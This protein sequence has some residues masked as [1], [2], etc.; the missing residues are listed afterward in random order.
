MNKQKY[1]TKKD[2]NP[3]ELNLNE[4]DVNLTLEHGH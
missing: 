1:F 4:S 2:E 3:L